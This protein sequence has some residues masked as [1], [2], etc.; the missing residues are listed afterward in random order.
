VKR[1]DPPT[2]QA[3][4]RTV[5]GS[6]QTARRHGDREELM[7]PPK[8]ATPTRTPLVLVHVIEH[9]RATHDRAS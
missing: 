9:L 2:R 7:L 8:L 5:R 6:V 3:G 1:A 4:V